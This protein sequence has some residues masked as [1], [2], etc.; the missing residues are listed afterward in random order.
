[1]FLLLEDESGHAAK[2]N[3]DTAGKDSDVRCF[4]FVI[5]LRVEAVRDTLT[6]EKDNEREEEVH[7]AKQELAICK[8]APEH[9]GE[10]LCSL[11]APTWPCSFCP[12]RLASNV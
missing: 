12:R 3:H 5:N 8:L 7:Y 9:I 2:V 6:E 1:M 4:F 11:Q 10:R